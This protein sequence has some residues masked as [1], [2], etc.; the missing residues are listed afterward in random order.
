MSPIAELYRN[1]A[2]AQ[3]LLLKQTGSALIATGFKDAGVT[4]VNTGEEFEALIARTDRL[5]EEAGNA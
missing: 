3:A 4:M 5:S 2:V 1:I